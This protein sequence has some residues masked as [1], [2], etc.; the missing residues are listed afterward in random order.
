MQSRYNVLFLCTGNSARSIMAEAIM[1]R[2][3]GRNFTAYSAGSHPSGFVRPEAIRQLDAAHLPTK[4]LR[5][6]SWDEF[7]GPD[8]PPL[9]FVFT[10]CDNA[11][12]EV[13]P[14]WPGQPMTAHWG[15]PD[16]AAVSGTPEQIERAFR[17]AF[18]SLDRRI[19][20]FI[21]LPL[22]SLDTFA[23]QRERVDIFATALFQGMAVEEMGD[24][25]L[26]YTPPLSSPWDPVQMAA[27]H[28]AAALRSE[29]MEATC[30]K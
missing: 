13:C 23:L 12:K 7:S 3:G 2:K 27:H 15:I 1:N 17:D 8:S 16:P 29:Q 6:K 22:Q 18:T 4:A 28:W 10:V 26:S 24:L 25:D 14:L 11:A 19:S 5:S 9:N 21:A 20:L 30:G